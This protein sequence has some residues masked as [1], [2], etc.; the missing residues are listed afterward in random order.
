MAALERAF[1]AD[2]KLVTIMPVYE[3]RAESFTITVEN[4][5]GSGSY[6]LN[7]IVTAKAEA[8]ADGKKFSHWEDG[9]G[10][11]LSYKESYKFY[12]AKNETITAVFVAD[13]AK[14]EAVGTTDIV[15]ALKDTA[16]SKL[17]FVSMST[18]PEG[19]TIVK[20]GVIATENAA[21]ANGTFTDATATFVRGNAWTG[22]AYRYSWT[23][24]KVAE[25]T[26]WY[27]RAYLVYA[28]AQGNTHT[29]YGSVTSQTM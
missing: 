5:S 13:S 22:S 16:N 24:G 25:G 10:K 2:N 18:V 26:T 17:T 29:V 6:E 7:A 20:A 19:C 21:V 23:K 1:A 9:T 4:G 14:V 28:D 15:E 3:L 12:A 27:V 8:A 11:V